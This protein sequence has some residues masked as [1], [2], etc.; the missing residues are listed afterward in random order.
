MSKNKSISPDQKKID[1]TIVIPARNEESY[2]SKCL[3]SIS[4]QDYKGGEIEIIV[5][6]GCSKDRTKAIVIYFIENINHFQK[7][8]SVRFIDNPDLIAASGMNIGFKAAKGDVVIPFSAHAYMSK[9]FIRKNVESLQQT[10][11]DVVGGLII[12][13]P[14]NT[15]YKARAIGKAL[16]SKFALGGIKA[17]TGKKIE[18]MENPS[19]G[20]YRKEVF[21]KYGYMDES[22]IRNTDYEYNLRL[23]RMGVK[24]IFSPEIKSFYFNRPDFLSLYKQY[25]YT[26]Y[27]KAM[28]IGEYPGII[29]LRHLIPTFFF[30]TLFIL[31]IASVFSK[32]CLI[33]FAALFM[34]YL[35]GAIAFSLG[36]IGYLPILPVV[37]FIIHFGYGFGFIVGFIK[38][39][40]SASSVKKPLEYNK[41]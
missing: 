12:S 15:S 41:D 40:L 1:V 34:L 16:N 9:D 28:M 37:F 13:A 24:I 39:R 2:I 38:S 20:A 5:V 36:N 23:S 29:R 19:F 35:I 21:E 4:E 25:F 18:P 11:A 32:F 10:G 31:L 22:L 27:F 14:E 3:D 7:G 33:P 6:D 8:F 26:S 30:L 17:R